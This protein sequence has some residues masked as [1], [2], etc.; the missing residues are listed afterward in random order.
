[1]NNVIDMESCIIDGIILVL[2]IYHMSKEKDK[3]E[4]PENIDVAR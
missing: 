2:K 4:R 3:K 1:M